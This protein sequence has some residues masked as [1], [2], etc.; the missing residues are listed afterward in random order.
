MRARRPSAGTHEVLLAHVLA[1]RVGSLPG[2]VQRRQEGALVLL[3]RQNRHG[4]AYASSVRPFPARMAG[5]SG[6]AR[7]PRVLIPLLVLAVGV[8]QGFG[9]FGYALL[10]PAVNADLVHSYAVAGLLGTLNLTAYLGGTLLVTLT[11]G[12][13]AP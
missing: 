9:R 12:R 1:G 5:Q 13:L 8:A 7:G 10:L 2:P 11:A 6:P 3:P 4:A